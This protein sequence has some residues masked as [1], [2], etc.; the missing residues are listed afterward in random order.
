MEINAPIKAAQNT[1]STH[2]ALKRQCRLGGCEL[3]PNHQ[4]LPVL[5]VPAQ[6]AKYRPQEQLPEVGH[7]RT[8]IHAY[9]ILRRA[10]RLERSSKP[11]IPQ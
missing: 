6:H 7:P 10:C 9:A 4:I 3:E 5:Q 2:L 1:A 11:A 8:L